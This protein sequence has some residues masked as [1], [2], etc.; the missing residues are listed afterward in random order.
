MLNFLFS[1]SAWLII[2]I[3]YSG[4]TELISGS[5]SLCFVKPTGTIVNEFNFNNT[6]ENVRRTSS[7]KNKLPDAKITMEVAT[8]TINKSK[9]WQKEKIYFGK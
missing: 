7:K 2:I 8:I 3:A 4:D 5:P 9:K 6:P 1:A